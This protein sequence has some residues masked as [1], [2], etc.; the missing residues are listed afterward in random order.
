MFTR[1]RFLLLAAALGA[2][3]LVALSWL[4]PPTAAAGPPVAAPVDG[5]GFELSNKT[6]SPAASQPGQPFAFTV[7]L[8]NTGASPLANVAVTDTLPAELI[9]ATGSLT[10]TSGAFNFASG[11]ITWTGAVPAGSVVS[12]Q[13]RAATLPSAVLGT[14]ITN[15]AVISGAGQIFS[16]TAA[17][18]LARTTLYL[19]LIMNMK[20]AGGIRGHVSLNGAPAAGVFLE[21]RHYNGSSFSTQLSLNTDANGDYNFANA[22]SLAPGNFYYVRYLNTSHTLGRLSDWATAEIK[23][24]AAG[25]AVSAGDFDLADIALAAP[26]PG[27][28]VGLPAPFQWTRRPALPGDSYQFSLFDPNGS[29][30]GQT[31]P[32]GYV[33]GVTLTGVP[34]A[35]HANTTYGWYVAVN[36]PDGGYG[37]SYYYREIRFSSTALSGQPSVAGG[38][39]TLATA[40]PA[41]LPPR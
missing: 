7:N 31:T 3:P 30:F 23:T 16:R 40:R 36:T 32:L 2:L 20:P 19:P 22:P 41:D 10:A 9:Y 11:I 6:V 24:Y 33:S 4:A 12:I 28:T 25:D 14:V 8:T 38:A 27:A 26:N 13:Y 29:A 37:E 1:F 35:F 5:N 34:S 18:T 17:V 15:T 21:L 39:Q